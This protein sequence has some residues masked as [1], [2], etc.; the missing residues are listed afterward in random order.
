MGF[1]QG[2]SIIDAL[3]HAPNI[4]RLGL[5]ENSNPMELFQSLIV[6][7]QSG[8][9][10]LARYLKHLLIELSPVDETSYNEEMRALSCMIASRA[11]RDLNGRT[12]SFEKLEIELKQMTVNEV[13]AE[14]EALRPLCR[15]LGVHLE[16]GLTV[17]LA[18]LDRL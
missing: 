6:P 13:P 7:N 2:E 16:I 11:R 15:D 12:I 3:R 5:M 4:E 18:S 9:E 1:F 10:T 8:Q 14:V 17:H